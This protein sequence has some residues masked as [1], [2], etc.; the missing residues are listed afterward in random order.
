MLCITRFSER[1]KIC[2]RCQLCHKLLLYNLVSEV[3]LV[4]EF[5]ECLCNKQ[6]FKSI[7]YLRNLKGLISGNSYNGEFIIPFSVKSMTLC[8]EKEYCRKE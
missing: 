8:S 5:K 7:L 4:L 6:L 1:E 3:Q 2:T